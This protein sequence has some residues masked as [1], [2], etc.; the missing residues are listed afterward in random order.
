LL[1]DDLHHALALSHL[2]SN[3]FVSLGTANS[4][5][6]KLLLQLSNTVPQTICALV[7]SNLHDQVLIDF[8][9]SNLVSLVLRL[10]PLQL[11][12][13]SVNGFLKE[14]HLN[15]VLLMDVAILYNDLLVMIL[16][17]PFE[18]LDDADL[19]LF[20]VIDV[21]GHPV[22]SILERPDVAFILSNLR[23]GS[24]NSSLHVLLLESKVFNKETKVGIESVELT[25]FFVFF[26]RLILKIFGL[27]F[28]WSD[29]FLE[30]LDA[31]IEHE[32]KFL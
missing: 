23:I 6:V 20:V 4:L 2:G 7:V 18:F 12:M 5:V 30:L 25:Q 14:R 29:L 11:V 19:E 27:L 13:K 17:E 10:L 28:F 1:V 31:V 22:D 15:F 24:A 26:I 32:L 3:F 8:H 16:D 9:D 21:L